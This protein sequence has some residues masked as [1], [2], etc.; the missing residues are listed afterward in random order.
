MIDTTNCHSAIFIRITYV[1]LSE[2]AYI[3][4]ILEDTIQKIFPGSPFVLLAQ[5]I[6]NPMCGENKLSVVSLD[7]FYNYPGKILIHSM[8]QKDFSLLPS[9]PSSL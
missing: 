8:N 7:M 5:V 1:V 2:L 4:I 3:N 9:A 6:S